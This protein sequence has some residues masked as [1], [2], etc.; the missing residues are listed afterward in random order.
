MNI[1]AIADKI[2][3]DYENI[4][5][6]F[7]GDVAALGSKL[8]AFTENCRIDGLEAAMESKDYDTA[9]SEAKKIRKAAEKVG[10]RD[11]KKAAEHAENAKDDKLHSAV[12]SLVQKYNDVAQCLDAEKNI[13]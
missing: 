10:L 2:G 8:S 1:S 9:R 13:N 6:D 11:L 3:L 7:C 4:I 12:A 5:E